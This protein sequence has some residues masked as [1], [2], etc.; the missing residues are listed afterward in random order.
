MANTMTATQ[1]AL[2]IANV[3]KEINKQNR[4]SVNAAAFAVKKSIERQT[5][6]ATKGSMGFSRMDRKLNRSGK[7]S[8]AN[9]QAS[10]LRV[11]Y[12][13]VG[14]KR[15][16][17][18]IVARGPWGLIEYG[19]PKHQIIPRLERIAGRGAARQRR[20]RDLDIAFGAQGAFTN[21]SPLSPRAGAGKPVY[22]VRHPG[23]KGKAPFK[24][25]VDLARPEATKK[26]RAN[27][28][29]VV[30]NTVRSG[31]QSFTYIRG[32]SSGPFKLGF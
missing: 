9:P 23:T 26:L 8:K 14:E 31:R 2:R 24:R 19:S 20:Q 1:F 32:S 13:I 27:L 22:K 7:L 11:G 5:S 21:V 12:D 25:G 28:S 30:A 18:L 16:T 17:A 29:F 15:P 10:K 6:I 4:K 3:G